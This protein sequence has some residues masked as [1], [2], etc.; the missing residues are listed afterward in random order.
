VSSTDSV[1]IY[2]GDDGFPLD[3]AALFGREAPLVVEVGFGNGAFLAG[4]SRAHPD[5]NLIGVE[6]AATSLSRGV[7]RVRREG[8]DNVRLLCADARMLVTD[9]LPERSIH[10]VYVNFPDPWPKD[11]HVEKRLLADAFFR[12]LSTRLVDGGELW[13]TTD[14]ADYYEFAVAEG[15]ATKLYEVLPGEPPVSTLETKY[16]QRWQ[17]QGIEINHV[18]FRLRE[19]DSAPHPVRLEVVEVAHARLKGDLS[20]VT[21]FEKQVHEFEAGHVVLLDCARTLDGE[22]LHVE[23][24]VEE[25]DLRQ[26]L[27]VEVRNSPGGIYVELQHFGRPA[28][29]RGVKKAVDLVADWLA[30]LGMEKVESAL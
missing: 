14:H 16:A 7:G 29:T 4:L 15:T 8:L 6:I 17:S 11:K 25:A 21:A 1:R 12:V 22:R 24:I 10:R 18:V 13:L 2:P 20:T 23:C 5:W 27:I 26:E 3:A 30:S 9:M 28:I 19:R